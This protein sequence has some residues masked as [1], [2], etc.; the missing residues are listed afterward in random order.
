LCGAEEDGL[1]LQQ[2]LSLVRLVEAVENVHE[3]GLPGA[4]L[5]EERVHLALAHVE[6]DVVVGDDAGKSL[7]DPT[8]LEDWLVGH[9]AP[10][11]TRY[12]EGRAQARPSHSLMRRPT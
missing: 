9:A 11:L 10:I 1:S 8:H 7:R 2:N 4:V 6:S 12:D 5:T 3:G